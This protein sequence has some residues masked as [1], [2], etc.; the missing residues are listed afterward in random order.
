MA[1]E[2]APGRARAL[3]SVSSAGVEASRLFTDE[4][5]HV[6]IIQVPYHLGRPNTGV[7]RGPSRLVLG[8]LAPALAG[9]GV[10]TSASSVERIDQLSGELDMVARVTARTAH[11]VAQAVEANRLPVVLAGDCNACVGVLGGLARAN[12]APGVLWF[13]AHGD[14]NTPETSTS[15]FLDGMALA[16]ATGRCHDVLRAAAGLERP[17]AEEAVVLAGA[18]DL[19]PAEELH[20]AQSPMQ[21]VRA[22]AMRTGGGDALAPALTVLHDR[23]ADLYIHL[24][25]DAL[26][27]SDA[28]ATGYRVPGGISADAMAQAL[29]LG[30]ARFQVRALAVTNYDALRDTDDRTLAVVMRMVHTVVRATAAH[31]AGVA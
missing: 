10:E 24:D 11:E 3:E 17:V 18:R 29:R 21:L 5:M 27:P 9:P 14:L 15:G 30:A 19:D 13:D 26:D 22:A 25:L 31:R 16:V 28:P 1:R 23:R 20:L 6:A 7:G 12:R 4:I 2:G 8:G